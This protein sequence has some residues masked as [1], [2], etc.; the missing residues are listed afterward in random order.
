MVRGRRR[1]ELR[2]IAIGF[3]VVGVLLL[4]VR[5]LAGQFLI[6]SLVEVE[7]VRPAAEN[8]WTILTSALRDDAWRIAVIGLIALAG[9]W[10]VGPGRRAERSLRALGPYLAG[11][12][13]LRRLRAPL[14]RAP[15]VVADR[16]L[17][18]AAR[19][20]PDARALGRGA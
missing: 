10:L 3:I 4:V 13:H 1:I 19:P 8:T 16:A 5:S 2:A 12:P 11:R 20:D 17:P 14:V 15:L 9:I 18:A 7:T 6:E